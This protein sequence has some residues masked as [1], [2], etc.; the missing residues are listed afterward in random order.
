ML[1]CTWAVR[2]GKIL[3]L[4]TGGHKFWIQG[5]RRRKDMKHVNYVNKGENLIIGECVSKGSSG[6]M[7]CCEQN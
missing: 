4:P 6:R 2:P 7:N 3:G 1:P 5:V